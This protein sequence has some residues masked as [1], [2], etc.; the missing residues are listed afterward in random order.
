M[1]REESIAKQLLKVDTPIYIIGHLN[2]DYDSIC[3]SLCLAHALNKMGK[4]AKVY[5][6]KEAFVLLNRINIGKLKDVIE[7][8][9]NIQNP[10]SAILVDMNTTA[11]AGVYEHLFLN[12]NTK[13]NI[14]H[15]DNNNI[16]ANFK[17]VD[18][19]AGANCENVYKIIK[20]FEKIKNIKITNN[21]ISNL[22]ALGIITDTS[23]IVKSSNL[24][25][26]QQIVNELKEYGVNFEKLAKKYYY[27]LTPFQKELY[28]IVVKSKKTEDFI[29]MF[30]VDTRKLKEEFIHHD[31]VF[32][33]T[34]LMKH[35]EN[36]I[37]IFEQEYDGFSIW[38]FRS[39]DVKNYPVNEIAV[40]LGGGGHK[41][42]SG[43]TIKNKTSQEVMETFLNYFKKEEELSQ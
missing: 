23:D 8:D 10:Y 31:F 5:F 12:A 11:R 18:E 3:S 35:N 26:T 32:V 39:E 17:F 14:D 27:S 38:E 19:K 34:E 15:H 33:L 40:M 37:T 22:L 6:T 9:T 7:T 42:A 16:V 13:I 21:K 20:E 36:T 4:K 25:Q 28:K 41:N 43:A 24:A 30:Y 29:T 2:S 1:K